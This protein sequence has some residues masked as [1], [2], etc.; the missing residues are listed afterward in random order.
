MLAPADG[1]IVYQTVDTPGVTIGGVPAQVTLSAIVPGNAGLYQIQTSVPDGV[2]AGDDV[3]VVVTM[4]S[5]SSDTV[6]IA[7]S[8]N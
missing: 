4:P 8:G 6:T 5:G 2:Q 1:S 7:V 3:A